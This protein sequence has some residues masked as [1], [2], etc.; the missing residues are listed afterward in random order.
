MA[1]FKLS[2]LR[3]S[4]GGPWATSTTYA[5]DTVVQFNGK[6][7][8]CLAPHTSGTF[9]T[10]LA[11][12]Y[13]SLQVDGKS[14][15]GAWAPSTDYV[16]GNLVEYGGTV[17]VCTV[18][19]TSST[20]LD[21]S[22][23]VTYVQTNN[24]HPAWTGG[25]NY[26]VGDTVKYGGIVYTCNTEHTSIGATT[27]STVSIT[28]ITNN[29]STLAITGAT[30]N[31][32]S[33]T[34]SFTG[35]TPFI[36]GQTIVV[37][38]VVSVSGNYN[39]TF[40]VSTTGAGFV[41]FTS[42][43]IGNYT[44]GGTISY[45]S[46]IATINYA[47][48]TIIPFLPGESITITGSLISGYNGTF[49][50][51]TSSS[52]Q[53]TILNTTAPVASSGGTISGTASLG[54]E[55]NQSYWTI[56]YSN[57]DYKT[58]WTSGTRY[59]INDVVKEGAELFICTAANQDVTFT[60]GHWS[61]YMPGSELASTWVI[62]TTY[63]QG[64][65][66]LYGGYSYISNT[67]N[68]IGN[69]PTTDTTDWTIVTS[70]FT[71]S[72]EWN[73]TTTYPVGSII[74]RDG[75]SYS[76][77]TNNIGQ[78]PDS[79]YVISSYTAS[80]SSGTTLKVASTS[81][82][83]PG[84]FVLGQG[85][86][87]GQYISAVVDSKTLTLNIAPNGTITDGATL[88]FIGVNGA[89]WTLLVPGA[90][91]KGVWNNATNYLIGD[92]VTFKNTTYY[93]IQSNTN[94]EPD[95]DPYNTYWVNYILHFQKNATGTPGDIS[96]YNSAN[97]PKYTALPIGT[98]TYVLRVNTN[99][100]AWSFI[101]SVPN[102][103]YVSA[104]N[105]QDLP[106]Y[107]TTWDQPWKTI[108]YACSTVGAGL[109]Y[110]S[111]GAQLEANREYMVQEMYYWMLT[112]KTNQTAPFT[113]ASVFDQT[114][115]LRDA[116]YVVDAIAYDIARGGNSQTVAATL[117]YFVYGSNNAFYNAA[118]DIEMPLF[119]AALT[120]LGTLITS[121]LSGQS[122]LQTTYQTLNSVVNPVT[123]TVISK[124]TSI[125]QANTSATNLL[126]IL[127]TALTNQSTAAV[128][129]SNSGL[130]ATIFVKT[131]TYSEVLPITIPENVALVGDELR[132]VAVQ[133][134]NVIDTVATATSSSTNL[135]TAASTVNMTDGV[136]VQ[137]IASVNSVGV[138]TTL[139]GL[140]SGQTYYIVG[141]SVTS[142][143]FGITNI[144]TSYSAVA[145]TNYSV[146]LSAASGA[147]W[148]V[149]KTSTGGYNVTIATGGSNY[150]VGDQVK[151]IGSIIGGASPTNDI[152]I[153]VT[154]V[155]SGTINAFTF[156]GSSLSNPINVSV[157]NNAAAGAS[158]FVARSGAGFTLTQKSGGSN[159]TIGD[160]IKIAGTN[161]G[162]TSPTN[163]IIITVATTA[164]G[165]IA[166]FTSTGS[167]LLAL[168]TSTGSNLIYGGG[169][170]QNMFYMR[171][172]SGL[173]NMTITGLLGTL[174]A[175][176]SYLIAR[177]TGP[178]YVSLDPGTGPNDTS[179]WIF[180]KSPYVQNVSTFGTGC[181]GLKIDGTLHAGGNKSIVSNDF[182]QILSDGIGIWCYGPG[183]LTEA[184]S[185]FSYYNY[186]GYLAEA[187]GRIRATNGNSSYGTYGVVA[188]GYDVTET[189]I[190]GNV[191][192]QSTQVQAS[193][194]STL[195]GSAT[196]VKLLYANA[197]SNYVQPTTNLLNYS[198]AFTTSPWSNDS[199]LTL[200]KNNTAPTGLTE[201]WILTG[202]SATAQ[203][204]YIYQNITIN[205][206][207]ST[208]YTLSLYVYQGTAASIDLSGIFSGT[209]TVTSNINYVFATNTLTP[210]NANGGLLPINYGS[211]K[212][213]VAGW[214]KIWMSIYD[215][216][217][218]NN[219]LQWRLY[220]KGAAAG[221]SGNYSIIYGAQTEVSASTYTPSF[222]LETQSNR[223]TAF[224][225]Y[226]I[227]GAGTGAVVVGDE[228]RSTSIFNARVT[229]PG[230]GAGGAG[231]LTASNFAQTG[232]TGTLSLALV[233]Q[234]TA[235]NYI[236]MRAYI[237]AGT[238][239]GQYGYISAYNSTTKVAQ[240]LQ[241]SFDPL[242]VT[243]TTVSTNILQL[244]NG[245]DFSKVYV[246]M[247][248]QFI[249]KYF[250][251]TINSTNLAQ[252]TCT[253]SVGGSTNTLTVTTTA[254]LALNMPIYFVGTTFTAVTTGYQYYISNIIDSVTIQISAQLGQSAV[255][256]TTGSGSTTVYY[257]A[258]NSY[259]TSSSTTNMTV[260][261]PILFTGTSAGNI[262]TGTTY[263]ITDIID[264]SNFTV[265]ASQINL[266]STGTTGS[267]T[268]TVNVGATATLVP[269][270]PIV[271]TG[272]TFGNIVANTKY[273]ISS[274]VD[275]ANIQLSTNLTY[276]TVTAT[277]SG[278]N[279]ITCSSTT[280]FIAGN[281]IKF[282]GTTFGNLQVETTYYIF[283]SP[284]SGTQFQITGTATGVTAIT[285]NTAAGS[286]TAR[287]ATGVFALT[288]T[289]GTMGVLSTGAKSTLQISYN[290]S[291]T[292][293]FN[294]QL[295]GGV[296]TGTTYYI[297]TFSSVSNQVTLVTTS[298]GS[299]S[300]T[301]TTSSGT[302]ALAAVG[303]DHINPGTPIVA[304]DTSSVYYIE[305]RTTFS[306]PAF[307]YSAMTSPQSATGTWVAIGYGLNYFIALPNTGTGA[308][309]SVDG[310]T[311]TAITMPV[312]ASWTGIAYG[313]G[314][315]VAVAT[316]TAT[317]YVSKNN[318]AS[319][320]S[321]TLPSSTTWNSVAYGNG[322]F[323]ATSNG[324]ATA[325][326]TNFGAS[327]SSNTMTSIGAGSLVY[328]I[329]K[330]VYVA[331]GG[332]NYNTTT[333]GVTWTPY[334]SLAANSGTTVAY[335]NGRFVTV[336]SA[337]AN[338][339]Y[340]FDAITWYT[341][342]TSVTASFITYGQGIFLATATNGT[343]YTSDSGLAWT[344]RTIPNQT[345]TSVAFGYTNTNT[346]VFAALYGTNGGYNISAGVRAKGRA[347]ITSGVM[348]G[349]N[350]W[351]PGSGY[352]TTPT[353]AF[354]DPN[355]LIQAT[356]TPRLGN[357]TL[358]N[359]TFVSRGSGYSTT[360]TSITV[361]GNGY[362]DQ[363]QT[364]YNVIMNNLSSLP[365]TGSDL[366]ISGNST[367]YKVT[368]ATAVYGTVAPNI[369][370]V[371]SINPPMTTLLSASN[372]TSVSI[373]T[374]YSQ[375][376]LTNHD[377]LNIGYG[378][379]INSNYPGI[380]TAGYSAVANN[381]AVEANFGRVFY[382][383]SDQDG[384]FK[385]GNLFG[386]QQA[387]GII[388]LSTS[389]FGLTGLTTLS[390]GGIS[391]GGSSVTINQFST[392]PTFI[393][394]SDGIIPTQRAIKSYLNNRLSAGSSNTVTT[395]A[396]A[397]NIVFSGS[398]MAA[399]VAGTSN[400]INVKVNFAGANAG[401]DGNMAAL[402]F[403]ARAFN[404]RSPIF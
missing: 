374:K 278:S 395:T 392:D 302:M 198:N 39:G 313:N 377:F 148:N 102:V 243:G 275:S 309:G 273:Y 233:D 192:N 355:V 299:T 42:S 296:A 118:V 187:G 128:P 51:Q 99:K 326:S 403:F 88:T 59:K 157:T 372:G 77:T 7:Y 52:T 131:G 248:V 15:L 318:G 194:Q 308:A 212:T 290:D 270:N 391:V 397:G 242:T 381:Q 314:Y 240:I 162:G 87:Y 363:Y 347:G 239:A 16:P 114:K 61:L 111:A 124:Y 317:A 226:E 271:F 264:S 398:V 160:T 385:V 176:D 64:D 387:T 346:G 319:W 320:A 28:S 71:I 277:T 404:H 175:L 283:G 284:I 343:A 134:A 37:S 321:T 137:F 24:W 113:S 140:T 375:A 286:M 190:T 9:I 342:N 295:F 337:G 185:V 323:V 41:T 95:F 365:I 100:P 2:R 184:V 62:S 349:I 136:P 281:P 301:L 345:F 210:S 218:A 195:S 80:G 202:T 186:A 133:P 322:I 32:T 5:R 130:T 304:L 213:L 364:G 141:P 177:P 35:A 312:S 132:G 344:K 101:N 247:P 328:G 288:S 85:F 341:A 108:Q 396:Q 158:F 183:A 44:S 93:C 19:H 207:S 50:V 262:A 36:T 197:G 351:E 223:Y 231:Y 96:Y 60:P 40:V 241:E 65:I 250:T 285:L 45:G 246:N 389:Q 258:Y 4:W 82:C 178:A 384:N 354:T 219:T 173:R 339:Q 179:A 400:K 280:G 263:Y 390:L 352:T 189:P 149:A 120:Q 386:V 236:G 129:Q 121:V 269:L 331:S 73:N 260:G 47:S 199:N 268:N 11:S 126:N 105:G 103:Y 38:N 298:N 3:V 379:F 161:I 303:W 10:D 125:P 356:I 13:W 380:P 29:A 122:G 169:A 23:F 370:A 310:S 211:Q 266:T 204:G 171:N 348:T 53:T 81:G 279:V 86:N 78:D 253:A 373:R 91:F 238:G 25:T 201:A 368:G 378:N 259:I 287:T 401:V 316:G 245:T 172:G 8:L 123:S 265:S 49:L 324:T 112:Q 229:D 293:T 388:T 254:P 67:S 56:L 220:A 68:N 1:E 17:Y 291:L 107:G 360:S 203:T 75:R 54:L 362:A 154:N 146:V 257:P 26:G 232:T 18:A 252:M 155:V 399:N 361:S 46:T 69:N 383:A 12:A 366:I 106:T 98:T 14:F 294:T 325:V 188:E 163:D 116:R 139:G 221:S 292:G 335:G 334:T 76:A 215:T 306:D 272:L 97:A 274:I 109:A 57:I 234:N 315:W 94:Q 20:T 70:G 249:P 357:G 181:V 31:G 367:I 84:M 63:Q 200:L 336:S 150:T 255:Q 6:M 117:M 92:T 251:T 261:L 83:Y 66:V 30:G 256:L 104:S 340:S 329:G 55:A 350:L 193:V 289:T 394:N 127:I 227:T 165:S 353:V 369:E 159:Y 72:G 224:A 333:D 153:T 216:N 359:P 371:V 152:I 330:F 170:L 311:W 382:T 48:Q 21:L 327:W 144:V 168:T 156:T 147:T 376:R 244:P 135:I 225:Y 338:S 79:N 110:T 191:F 305:P 167:S 307:T 217:G 34:L 196:L 235:T 180:R 90:M 402:E 119:I 27:T 209:S 138:S 205:P 143:Q 174:T 142:T 151:I 33:V 297:K 164:S 267:T 89:Y 214:Y 166:T 22:K 208:N 206:G 300:P 276:V 393:A 115:T 282:F 358:G 58:T 74:T 230:T 145:S 222:Y 332:T 43:T 182:T 237:S 228:L